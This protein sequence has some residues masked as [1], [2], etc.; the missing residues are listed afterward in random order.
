MGVA[1]VG[2]SLGLVLVVICSARR[3]AFTISRFGA[4]PKDTKLAGGNTNGATVA[5]DNSRRICRNSTHASTRYN[6]MAS[7]VVVVSNYEDVELMTSICDRG[8]Y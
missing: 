3:T 4:L 5:F 7:V 6:A 1:R 2:R 8:R